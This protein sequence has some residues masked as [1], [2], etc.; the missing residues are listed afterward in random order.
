MLARR[1]ALLLLPVSLIATLA[2]APSAVAEPR[3]RHGLERLLQNVLDEG[4]PGGVL[5][6]RDADGVTGVAAGEADTRTGREARP[7]DRYRIGSNTKTMVAVVVLQLVQEG[8]LEL[9]DPV[10]RHVDGFDLDRRM[11]V[12]HLL[13]QT[14]GL[15]T[16][17]ML[18]RDDNAYRKNR[19][20]HFRP[21]QLVRIALT[22]PEPRPAPG[23]EWEYSNTNY[24]LAG[25]VVEQVT[26]HSLGYELASRIFRP[27]R[28]R[29][30]SFPTYSPFIRGRH[31]HGYRNDGSDTT[32][33]GMSWAWAAGAV[34]STTRDET[35]FMRALLGGR[36]L[37]DRRLEQMLDPGEFGYGLGIVPIKLPCAPG[38]AYGHDGA[39]FGYHSATISTADGSRQ[40][41]VGVNKWL[42]TDSG[43]LNSPLLVQ[44][45]A[46]ALC[47]E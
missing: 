38:M 30:T 23:T 35:T 37:D 21:E 14:S 20:R 2:V 45:A 29:D 31:L 36:L 15:H 32:V 46:A 4:A 17:T 7:G 9:D 27:L 26:G 18:W 16:E 24:V 8:R 43:G 12:R 25:M 5:A 6:A 33:Y 28:M 40:A 47:E 39:V 19:F 13:Q 3:E 22:N 34:V 1:L 11:T 44:A 10:V 41:A 42:L